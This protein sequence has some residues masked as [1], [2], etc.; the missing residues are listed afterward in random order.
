MAMLVYLRNPKNNSI[1][2]GIIGLS[3][4]TFFFGLLVTLWRRDWKTFLFFSVIY[5]ASFYFVPI[6][7]IQSPGSF[8]WSFEES[9]SFY[10]WFSMIYYF[11]VNILGFLFYNRIFTQGLLN[12]GYLP[13]SQETEQI[14]LH[15]GFKIPDHEHPID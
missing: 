8:S 2:P 1:R 5:L 14:L 15:K 3:W 4:T 6:T 12:Q 11:V 13:I 9:G 10:V 7:I